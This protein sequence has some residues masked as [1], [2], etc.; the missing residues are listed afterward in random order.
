MH[1]K[2]LNQICGTIGDNVCRVLNSEIIKQQVT[3]ELYGRVYLD[4][5]LGIS[6]HLHVNEILAHMHILN[7]IRDTSH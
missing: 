2:I 6:G 5:F 7:E 1:N 3:S 4:I